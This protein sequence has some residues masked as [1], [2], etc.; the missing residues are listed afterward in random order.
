[1]SSKKDALA[2]ERRTGLTDKGKELLE[3][4]I[5]ALSS[6]KCYPTRADLNS[7][8]FSRDSVRSHFGSLER[9]K[10]LAK[11]R[12]PKVVKEVIEEKIQDPAKLRLL[13]RMLKKHKRFVIAAAENDCV[14]D[15]KAFRSLKAL[16]KKMRALL[17]IL[18]M[19]KD[20]SRM[21]PIL[22]NEFWIFK[23]TDLN[24]NFYISAIKV[25]PK[26]QNP[27]TSLA[28]VG[29]R[30][31]SMVL[32]SPKQFLE[33]VAVGDNKFPHVLMSTGAITLHKKG[34]LQKNDILALDDHTI[35][36]ILVEIEDNQH[37]HFRQLQADDNG[38]FVDLGN[39]FNG[40]KV[41]KLLPTHFVI[42]DY[43]VTETDPRAAK[44]W[45]EV[46]AL[47]G[48]PKR[49]HHDFFSGVSVNH[50]EEHNLV[51]RAQ[52][53]SENRLSLE[54]ELR[55]CAKVLD[56]ETEKCD[57]VT[58]VDSNHHDFVSKHYLPNGTYHKDP[59]NLAFASK[60]M[61]AMIEGHNPIRYAL[62]TLI[63]LKNPHKVKWLQ[64]DESYRVAG[65]EVGAH[66]D[67]GSN[68]SQGSANTLEK[69][70]GNCV[71]GHSHTPKIVRGFWQ[72]GTSSY[73]KLP[74]MVGSSSWCH[75]SCLIY[76]NGTRQFI[77]VINGKWRLHKG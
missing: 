68:G 50:H 9:L 70:Y 16:C 31:G 21:D 51:R 20:L 23:K 11:K 73:L 37:F 2:R 74:Y 66:G 65:I 58:I 39:Y 69:A 53:M 27:L 32:A 5:E 48:K 43:H 76:P 54:A 49:I 7:L 18:P 64:R 57:E 29:Q 42:G 36:A 77:N 12:N 67:K 6:S 45:D 17:V 14:V 47:V 35:G 41:T 26:S 63:G 10:E 25:S 8:G 56:E 55:I 4:Y 72:V 60:L 33:F 1:M 15:R 30:N 3:A 28:R 19:G 38:A 52:L 62:E 13:E 75:T 59:Q 71:V 34:S 22:A 61:V 24:S 40:D 44:A 46:S